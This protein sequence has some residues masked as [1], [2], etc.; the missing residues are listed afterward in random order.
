MTENE[1]YRRLV[2][3]AKQRDR[4]NYTLFS[5]FLT[6]AEQQ[7]AFNI[8]NCV[9]WGGY[10]DA[11]RKMAAMYPDYLTVREIEWEMAAVRI[12]AADKIVYNH[13]DYLGSV[14][15]LGISRDVLGDII[16]GENDACVVCTE[17][18]APHI[19]QQLVQVSRTS[20]KCEIIKL[21]ELSPPERKFEIIE[22]SVASG[23]L[24]CV[25]AMLCGKGRTFAAEII[26]GGFVAV[27]F[28]E[29]SSVSYSVKQ[30]DVLSIRKFGKFIFDG[31]QRVTKKGRSC[32]RFRKYV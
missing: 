20:V 8:K 13:K 2:D 26:R 7:A 9:L 4:N 10:D 14:M 27:N 1:T 29:N 32:V 18:I 15:G 12:T 22:G 30:G 6:P 16:I 11:D 25:V 17:S 21:S 3:L 28:K 24:D 19:A 31:E 23:R 5:K